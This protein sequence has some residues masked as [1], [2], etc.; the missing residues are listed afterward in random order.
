MEEVALAALQDE[1]VAGGDGEFAAFQPVQG[2]A[3]RDND[4]FREIVPVRD[5]GQ[6]V[7]MRWRVLGVGP[8]APNGQGEAGEAEIVY[9]ICYDLFHLP[10]LLCYRAVSRQADSSGR[11]KNRPM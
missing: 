11:W 5:F 10:R 9:S 7:R 2:A 1:D 3:F 4:E 6:I 8:H